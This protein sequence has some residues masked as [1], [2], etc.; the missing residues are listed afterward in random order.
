MLINTQALKNKKPPEWMFNDWELGKNNFLYISLLLLAFSL[1]KE[2]LCIL[3][4]YFLHFRDRFKLH[5]V[6]YRHS[7]VLLWKVF[8]LIFK[9][10][11]LFS[12][13]LRHKMLIL[14]A[15]PF[16]RWV[17]WISEEIISCL[18]FCD[19]GGISK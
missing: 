2:L 15:F 18:T 16:Y 4:E 13:S 8:I 19:E 9:S 5:F 17:N 11:F 10:A 14:L 7:R 3:I 1:F 12:F 6:Q